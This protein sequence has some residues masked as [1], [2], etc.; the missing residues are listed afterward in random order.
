[1]DPELAYEP[2]EA[3][4]AGPDGLEALRR[5]VADAPG[6]LAPGGWLLLEHGAGQ[7][8]Q[9]RGLLSRTGFRFV[10]TL[11][12]LHGLPRVSEGRWPG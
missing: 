5:I 2:R 7:G 11:S 1:V 4:A 12:D 8:E 10:T 3:L 9:V 6:H